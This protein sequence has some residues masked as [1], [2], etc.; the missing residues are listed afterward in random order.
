MGMQQMFTDDADFSGLLNNAKGVK[1]SKVIHKA[2]I[3]VNELGTEAAAA[4]VQTM[5]GGTRGDP[6]FIADHPFFFAIHN[7]DG[8]Y[9]AGRVNK[10]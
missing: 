8:I 5:E 7:E 4:T 10:F 9:F 3:E 2:F 1:V 6:W